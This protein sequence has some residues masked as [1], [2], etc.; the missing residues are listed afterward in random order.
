MFGTI[1][2]L[3]T[4]KD[5][6]SYPYTR[7]NMSNQNDSNLDR[8]LTYRQRYERNGQEVSVYGTF[9]REQNKASVLPETEMEVA[10]YGKLPLHLEISAIRSLGDATGQLARIRMDQITPFD[11]FNPSVFDPFG[12][13]TDP[14]PPD[15]P[16]LPSSFQAAVTVRLYPPDGRAPSEWNFQEGTVDWFARRIN[17]PEGLPHPSLFGL[18]GWWRCTVTP[19]SNY[20]VH[21][22]VSGSGRLATLPVQST[23]IS[24]RLLNRV[25]ALA[26]EAISLQANVENGVL[27]ISLSREITDLLGQTPVYIKETISPLNI[28]SMKQLSLEVVPGQVCLDLINERI[29]HSSLVDKLRLFSKRDRVVNLTT[30]IA[31]RLRIVFTD[32]PIELFDINLAEI[33]NDAAEIF[34]LISPDLSTFIPISLLSIELGAIASA[35]DAIPFFDIPTDFSEKIENGFRT[36]SREIMGYIRGAFGR[37]VARDGVALRA[38]WVNGMLRVEHFVDPPKPTRE[39]TPPNPTP[40]V[41]TGGLDVGGTIGGFDSGANPSPTPGPNPGPTKDLSDPLGVF[42]TGFDVAAGPAL[43]RLDQTQSIVVIM[44]ENRS[45]DHLLG[46]LQRS[47]SRVGFSYDGIPAEASNAPAGG[48]AGRVPMV[49]ARSIGL[50]TKIPVSPN[51]HHKPVMFQIGG[52]TPETAGS[53][54]MDGFARNLAERTDSSQVALTYYEEPD[55]PIYYR[56]AD[57]FLVCDRW[58]SALP[59]PTWPNRWITMCGTT[60]DLD[61]PENSDPRL[62]YMTEHT[63]FDTLTQYGISWKYFESDLSLIRLFNNY[64]LDDTNVLPKKDRE[65]VFPKNDLDTLLSGFGPLPR[66]MFIEPNFVDVP[67][68]LANDD[69]PPA[70]L[71]DG[72]AFIAEIL[73]KFRSS[74]RWGQVTILITY[75]EHGGFY[76]HVPPPGSAHGDPG[77]V[78]QV[79]RIHPDGPDFLGVR[80]PTFVISPLV[81][82][83]S[84]SH[85]VFDH[86]SIIKTI[87]VHNRARLPRSVFKRFGERVNKAAHL[88]EVMNLDTPRPTPGAEFTTKKPAVFDPKTDTVSWIDPASDTGLV[89]DQKKNVFIY[90]ANGWLIDAKTGAIRDPKTN[91]LVDPTLVLALGSDRVKTVSVAKPLVVWADLTFKGLVRDVASGSLV[92]AKTGYLINDKSGVVFDPK[93]NAPIDQA[94]AVTIFGDRINITTTPNTTTIITSGRGLQQEPQRAPEPR[95]FHQSLRDM[96]KPRRRYE[97]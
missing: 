64:R 76:D 8:G 69:H 96:Y 83:P 11:P 1:N 87:L 70:D 17:F 42:P 2:A 77:W 32:Q 34:L 5:T 40:S 84:V 62:G 27:L 47:R 14:I 9:I 52:G 10:F 54:A 94:I 92:D 30:W 85:Q 13:T 89:F 97:P 49:R 82:G 95:D 18:S 86:T 45:F 22:T 19:M 36:Y 20:P 51:H 6:I 88:G 90:P 41:D 65:N 60:P 57:D 39:N 59:G 3:R 78:G 91:A 75:D 35:V 15:L 24:L 79:P 31:L 80:V 21:I 4:P 16:P 71:A 33:N 26:L 72:Q 73:E 58:F 74:G 25:F 50:N 28:P 43:S 63:I 56:L 81:A 29:Q 23:D 46:D 38:Q 68:G 37:L 66:V 44:M 7:G 12:N 61:N 53:G 55:L 93:T 48:F 67:G